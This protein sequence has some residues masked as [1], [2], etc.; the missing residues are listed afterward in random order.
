MCG[1]VSQLWSAAD[2]RAFAPEGAFEAGRRLEAELGYG[3]GHAQGVVTPYVGLRLG[4]AG[5]RAWRTG[6][7][8]AVASG[9]TLSLEAARAQAPDAAG[10][11]G[12]G[13]S[14]ML[15]GAMRW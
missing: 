10:G 8:W 11:D 4:D 2:A 12:G 9:A 14:L 3:L 7:R 6:A 15:R 1:E 5:E 13:H